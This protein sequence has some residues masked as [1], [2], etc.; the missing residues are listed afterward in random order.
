MKSLNLLFLFLLTTLNAQKNLN[1]TI[2]LEI[3]RPLL[4]DTEN[5]SGIGLGAHYTYTFSKSFE[6]SGFYQFT[7]G[8]DF[9]SDGRDI[10]AL[11]RRLIGT[12]LDS[13]YA[14][15][16]YQEVE[17]HTLGASI[18][19]LFINDN[20]WKY[21]VSLGGGLVLR[22]T[23]DV[24]RNIMVS[25]ESTD[26]GPNLVT[27]FELLNE[28]TTYKGT[29]FRIAMDVDY[30]FL[31][32]YTIGVSISYLTHQTDFDPFRQFILANHLMP[33]IKIGKKF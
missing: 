17:N 28:K 4:L 26:G 2:Q 19:W 7:R 12:S 14:D 22:N 31:Q 10:A 33:S 15:F 20:R 23:S 11:E 13:F 1:H 9:P 16:P 3:G 24:T 30:T 27:G 32:Q 29:F 5:L 8:N 25:F 18:G 21:G 6:V